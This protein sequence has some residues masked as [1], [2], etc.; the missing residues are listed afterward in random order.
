MEEEPEWVAELRVQIRRRVDP[1]VVLE[2]RHAVEGAI[3]GWWDVVGILAGE[4]CNWEPPTWAGLDLLRR[5]KDWVEAVAGYAFHRGVVGLAR[6]PEETADVQGLVAELDADATVVV[7]PALADASN[8]GAILRNAAALGAKAVLFGDGGVSPFERKAVRS[9]SGALFRLPVRVADSGQILRCLKA[10]KFRILGAD[11]GG[12]A[13]PLPDL[14]PVEGRVALVVGSEE[15]GL[16]SFWSRACDT[17]LR[18]P[19]TSG[20]DSLNAAAASAV[21]LWEIARAREE[22]SEEE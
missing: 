4:G 2:G 1:W 16:G 5:P 21:L 12:D 22:A 6:Q 11:A 3:G 10:G 7:C 15:R 20:V 8:A 17:K 19:M 14:G 18:I 9:S 13:A